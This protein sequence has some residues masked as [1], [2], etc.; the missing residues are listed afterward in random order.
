[1][2]GVKAKR[3]ELKAISDAIRANDD[4]ILANDAELRANDA[5]IKGVGEAI[6][7]IN[8]DIQNALDK[9][10]KENLNRLEIEKGRLWD[11]EMLLRDKERQLRDKERQLRDKERQLRDKER[12]LRD[13]ERQLRDEKRQLRDMGKLLLEPSNAGELKVDEDALQRAMM[14]ALDSRDQREGGKDFSKISERY[15]LKLLNFLEIDLVDGVQKS[16]IVVPED[17]KCG[18]FP[19]GNYLNEEQAHPHFLTFLAGELK[20][21]GVLIGEEGGFEIVDVRRRTLYDL[22]VGDFELAG[23]VDAA[24][25]PW[26]TFQ[27]LPIRQVRCSIELKYG[28][29]P[30]GE[31]FF[32][33]TTSGQSYAEV[34]AAFIFTEYP[35]LLHVTTSVYDNVLLE[36]KR[37]KGAVTISLWRGVTF[38]AVV[39]KLVEYL[40]DCNAECPYVLARH[41]EVPGFL[42][43]VHWRKK[44]RSGK[45]SLL[46]D[47]LE[48]LSAIYDNPD[49][50]FFHALDLLRSC[51]QNEEAP[52]I[53]TIPEPLKS[54]PEGMYT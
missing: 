14:K 18:S 9:N 22:N 36:V 39:F 13:K 6:R 10:D 19:M 26:G 25:V 43:T 2:K 34:V 41:E 40:K 42:E 46:L 37:E 15:S 53:W 49:E 16:P 7:S 31:A 30:K 12:Q 51:R 27:A 3:T 35:V 38:D 32:S 52:D 45:G 5:E 21:R 23:G 33:G 4:S 47:Q 50:R 48:S 28:K 17:F 29:A 1:M 54:V 11:K 20:A 24:I 44:L 8:V